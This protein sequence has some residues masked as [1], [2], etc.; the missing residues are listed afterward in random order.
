LIAPPKRLG[1]ISARIEDGK[2]PFEIL[3]LGYIHT[4]EKC[5]H[6]LV[7]MKY[8]RPLN[9]TCTFDLDMMG[10]RIS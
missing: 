6:D 7:P 4:Y 2:V 8:E 3:C 9:Q 1:I 10:N 5:V